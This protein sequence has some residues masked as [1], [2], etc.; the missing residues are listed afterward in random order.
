MLAITEPIRTRLAALPA[1]AGW[2]V[3]M[4]T[5]EVS[6][7]VV[8]AVDVRCSGGAVPS[9]KGGGVLITAEWTVTL[10]VKRGAGA[11]DEID[12]ALAAVVESLHGWMPG[13]HGG[14]GWEPLQLTRVTEAL[15]AEQGLAGYELAFTTGGRYMGQQ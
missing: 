7:A 5:D 3:R 10:V 1:L 6:R 11:A 15:Y 4:G 8:P 9:V 14:R 12:A 2:A 13:H